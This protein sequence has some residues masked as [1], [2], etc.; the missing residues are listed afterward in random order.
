[1]AVAIAGVMALR[2]VLEHAR[3]MVA[4]KTAAAVQKRLRRTLFDRIAELGPAY[5]GR[6]RSGALT[7]TL[8]DGVEQLETYFGQYLPQLLVSALTPIF[9]FAF[10]AFID[11]PVALTLVVFA[12]AALFLPSIWH[13]MDVRR[14]ADRQRAY[15]AFAAEF[16]D[17][18]QGLATLKA[19]G[20]SRA[21]ADHLAFKA[22]DLFRRTMWVL[23]TNVLARG[24]TDCAIAI[25]AAAALTVGAARV[26]AGEMTITALLVVLMMGVEIFRPMRDLRTVL[27]Q[28]MVGMSAAQGVYR[29]LDARPVVEDAPASG[30]KDL[31]PSLAFEDVTFRYPGARQT[32]HKGLSFA[33]APGERVGLVGPSGSGKSSVVRLLLRFFDPDEGRV[34]LGGHD[35]RTLSFEEIRSR[36]AV[37]SQ[38]A[39]LF[40]GTVG[41]NIRLGRPDASQDEVIAAARA[42][43]I[44][45]FVETLADGY[46]TV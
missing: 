41:D 44:H 17:S 43:N 2:G 36:I 3:A 11:L 9:I 39:Y 40:H 18:I 35:L 28:G 38:D 24:I 13:R 46:D 29:I 32:A 6:E 20:Q 21:R 15:A 33:V 14:S 45:G 16:L 37:V 31:A 7:L 30:A 8:I 23:G 12:L 22:R 42:A 1:P 34:T 5:V 19:F 10:V 26:E 25:G 4:H 27:H